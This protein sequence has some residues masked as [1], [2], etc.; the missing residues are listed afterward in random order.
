ML[1]PLINSS[2]NSSLSTL[3]LISLVKSIAKFTIKS[4]ANS[5]IFVSLENFFNATST[6]IKYFANEA[7]ATTNEDKKKE[8]EREKE[9]RRENKEREERREQKYEISSRLRYR[10]YFY[11]DELV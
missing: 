2:L 7:F 6:S 3:T 5:S 9:K 10:I 8:E 11:I 1:R 4:I